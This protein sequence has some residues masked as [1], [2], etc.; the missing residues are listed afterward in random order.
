MLARR[1]L[2]LH[3]V[4]YRGTKRLVGGVALE[5]EGDLTTRLGVGLVGGFSHASVMSTIATAFAP[6]CASCNVTS[7]PMPL[8]APVTTA[9]LFLMSM[10]LPSPLLE[11]L[12]LNP[13]GVSIPHCGLRA[14]ALPI[15]SGILAAESGRHQRGNPGVSGAPCLAS[16][17]L[18]RQNVT[19]P[20]DLQRFVDAQQPVFDQALAELRAGRKQTHWMWFIF[21][22]LRSL[23]RSATARRFGIADLA[24]ARAYAAHPLLG[25]RLM[26]CAHTLLDV[27]GRSA[28]QIFGS[29]DDLKLRSCMTLFEQAIGTGTPFSGV[30]DRYCN[31]ARDPL[32]LQELASDPGRA[33]PF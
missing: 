20:H 29:P 1:R 9:T 23:G 28:Q 12:S 13:L 22:Q 27:R 8:A 19:M 18:S 11:T 4:E 31:G 2:L 5:G 7:R 17:Y 16:R 14:P 6:R 30:I 26:T 15:R 33:G 21:P 24:E 3:L 10:K 25:S 32:T